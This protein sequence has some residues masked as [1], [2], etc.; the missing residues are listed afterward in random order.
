MRTALQILPG[1]PPPPANIA[2]LENLHRQTG[3]SCEYAPPTHQ[4]TA[5]LQAQVGVRRDTT[6]ALVQVAV[7]PSSPFDLDA[8][9]RLSLTADGMVQITATF[10]LFQS[11]SQGGGGI[12]ALRLPDASTP[13]LEGPTVVTAGFI[14]MNGA[15]TCTLV[16]SA[17]IAGNSSIELDYWNG[18]GLYM[19][20]A[21]GSLS[22]VWDPP[23]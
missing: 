22:V 19:D 5:T 23:S 18:T 21:G 13:N 14:D 10:S 6:I 3:C 17:P 12:G 7:P 8:F 4:A 15:A 2:A 20:L 1:P 16:W 11:V 9:G